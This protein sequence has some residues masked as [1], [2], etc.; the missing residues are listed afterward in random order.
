MSDTYEHPVICPK[1]HTQSGNDWSQCAGSCPV[2]RSP[3]FDPN[4]IGRR[5]THKEFGQVELRRTSEHGLHYLRM[6]YAGQG[7]DWENITTTPPVL[8]HAP[9]IDN[10][11]P[12]DVPSAQPAPEIASEPVPAAI[13][14]PS[15]REREDAPTFCPRCGTPT[16][17]ADGSVFIE[18]GEF[19]AGRKQAY[20]NE[21]DRAV[22][23]CTTCQTRFAYD[24][25]A[26][27]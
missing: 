22:Y 9:D 1:C 3:H 10:R 16:L 17:A 15:E 18:E 12:T 14:V 27:V 2:E 25:G 5:A 23:R 24:I 13:V 4:A 6:G 11:I 7:N 20:D 21:G 26:P 8:P 19:D